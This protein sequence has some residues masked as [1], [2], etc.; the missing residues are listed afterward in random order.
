[1]RTWHGK[2]SVEQQWVLEVYD[3]EAAFLNANPGM[4]MYIKYQMRW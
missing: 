4:K 1:M 3:V 2:V